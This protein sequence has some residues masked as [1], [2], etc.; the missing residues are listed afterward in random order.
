[1]R[2]GWIQE[3]HAIMSHDGVEQMDGYGVA[4][5]DYADLGGWLETFGNWTGS[6]ACFC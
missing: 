3:V 1:M 5:A 6:S 4:K 2:K